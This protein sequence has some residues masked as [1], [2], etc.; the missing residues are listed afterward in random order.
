MEQNYVTVNLFIRA[1]GPHGNE[2]DGNPADS[3]GNPRELGQMLREYR[4]VEKGAA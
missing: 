2:D 4:E 3:A 1:R